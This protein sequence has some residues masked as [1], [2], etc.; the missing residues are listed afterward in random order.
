[1]AATSYD[2][3]SPVSVSAETLREDLR[4]QHG[5]NY[6]PGCRNSLAETSPGLVRIENIATG[7]PEGLREQSDTAEVV[8]SLIN[9]DEKQ[10]NRIRSL[11]KKTC[12]NKRHMAVDPLSP[13]FD[14]SMTIR[15]RMDLFMEHAV[16]LATR[17]S[18]QAISGSR[19]QSPDEVG[20]LVLVTSTGFVAPG[21][22]VAVARGL[23]LP[24]STSRT[25]VNF[26][27]CAAA[28]SGMRVAAD[29]VRGR[30]TLKALVCCIE[31]SSVNAVYADDPNDIVISSLFGDGSAAMVVSAAQGC[32]LNPGELIVRDQFSYLVDD[33]SDGI[34][35]GVNAN[36]ITCELS[37]KLPSYIYSGLAPVIEQVLHRNGEK[38]EDID[39]WAIHPGGPKIIQE[40]TRSL[41]LD[42][43]VGRHSWDV[44]AEYGNMLSASLP[45]L[46]QRMAAEASGGEHRTG[47]AFSFAPG[48]TVEGF[49]FEL[50]T[51]P[52]YI[53]LAKQVATRPVIP[54][55]G[56]KNH[57]G[58]MPPTQA[59]AEAESRGCHQEAAPFVR[60]VGQKEASTAGSDTTKPRSPMSIL[61]RIV[62]RILGSS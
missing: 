54:S 14:T 37:Q 48:V 6:T 13:E 8:S 4:D 51:T 49:L 59:T 47:M 20:L 35:L 31:L 3:P 45:F 60:Q 22:D 50:V 19:V 33:T 42:P 34:V 36:G 23:G 46:L 53:P 30:P 18:R 57:T 43:V 56:F 7:V 52:C 44:L 32:S 5:Q 15:K 9:S 38:K 55:C 27:G 28:M 17:V 1:M 40:A 21:A 26:M 11:Y 39:H 41:D 58:T 16:P 62:S 25:T 10:A 12:I 24:A 61:R 29:F 2:Q